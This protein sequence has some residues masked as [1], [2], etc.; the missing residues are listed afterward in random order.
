L[1]E[2]EKPKRPDGAH[3]NRELAI[4]CALWCVIIFFRLDG[5]IGAIGLQQFYPS[6]IHFFIVIC[7]AGFWVLLVLWHA[8]RMEVAVVLGIVCTLFFSALGSF[9]MVLW[10]GDTTEHTSDWTPIVGLTI[11]LTIWLWEIY[12]P[13]FFAPLLLNIMTGLIL[14][15]AIV[16]T[17]FGGGYSLGVTFHESLDFASH[18]YYLAELSGGL[19]SPNVTRLYECN[20]LALFCRN[21]YETDRTE[22]PN[23]H[24]P[25]TLAPNDD[26]NTLD[27]LAGDELLY[28]YT[29]S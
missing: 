20:Q 26:L 10:V 3:S 24:D 21:V 8:V 28:R 22:I 16:S 11:S 14:V 18:H 19:E 5:L 9:T 12:K 25:I 1:V 29:P 7:V 6:L 4:I 15:Y 17:S 23:N 27:V 2:D 13:R